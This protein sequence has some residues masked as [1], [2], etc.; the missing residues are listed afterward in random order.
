MTKSYTN[1]TYFIYFR[2]FFSSFEHRWSLN[3]IKSTISNYNILQ[4]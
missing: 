1:L 3:Q 4:R 2:A